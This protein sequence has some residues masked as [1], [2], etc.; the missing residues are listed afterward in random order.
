MNF[1]G[2][3]RNWETN[4]IAGFEPYATNVPTSS[5]MSRAASQRFCSG[6]TSEGTPFS[7]FIS[8]KRRIDRSSVHR[9]SGITM[10]KSGSPLVTHIREFLAFDLC[11]VF[12]THF[13]VPSSTIDQVGVSFGMCQAFSN[14][15]V[16]SQLAK[17]ADST[18]SRGHTMSF[19]PMIILSKRYKTSGAN[20]RLLTWVVWVSL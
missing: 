19:F 16:S 3:F 9:C 10:M 2:C 14:W 8:T 13:P 7:R 20:I 12:H 18:S 15:F 1:F 4:S 11:H 5:I 6:F 17:I